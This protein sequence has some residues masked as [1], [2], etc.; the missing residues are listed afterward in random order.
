VCFARGKGLLGPLTHFATKNLGLEE[1]A[2]MMYKESNSTPY[3][4]Q[5]RTA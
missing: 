3:S 5:T 4:C 2:K 1:E